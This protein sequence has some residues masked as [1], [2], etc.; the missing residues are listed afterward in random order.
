MPI[1]RNISYHT[2][3]THHTDEAASLAYYLNEHG[4]CAQQIEDTV[5][6]P[7][8]DAET[9]TRVETLKQTWA[10][11][12]ENSDSGLFGLPMYVKQG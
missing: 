7:V 9:F 3:Q 1:T 6:L 11:F 8:P 5:E 10:M 12:W 4:V 2:I